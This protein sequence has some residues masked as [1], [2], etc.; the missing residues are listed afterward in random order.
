PQSNAAFYQ[1]NLQVNSIRRNDFIDCVSRTGP[2]ST[3]IHRW[4]I[5]TLSNGDIAGNRFINTN[6]TTLYV[7]GTNCMIH[8]N[9]FEPVIEAIG[10]S[11]ENIGIKAQPED[12]L[13]MVY[14]NQ[15]V[16]GIAPFVFQQES[17]ETILTMNSV[18]LSTVN[19]WIFSDTT[20]LNIKN[21]YIVQN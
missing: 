21:F 1:K 11:L 14:N 10:G 19:R 20:E 15:H 4:F 8:D 3:T 18:E 12:G 6:G 5:R 17:S 16:G 13:N 9:Y 2:N 7:S